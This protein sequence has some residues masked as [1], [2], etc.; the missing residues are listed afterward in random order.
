[1]TA[2]RELDSYSVPCQSRMLGRTAPS[3]WRAGWLV[4]HHNVKTTWQR[5]MQLASLRTKAVFAASLPLTGERHLPA[6]SLHITCTLLNHA[7]AALLMRVSD[8]CC[9]LHSMMLQC[10]PGLKTLELA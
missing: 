3:L 10:C 2:C 5:A 4:C 8:C 6:S 1:M 9:T 7:D